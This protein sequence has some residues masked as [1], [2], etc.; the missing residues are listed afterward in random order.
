MANAASGSVVSKDRPAA[1]RAFFPLLEAL[2]ADAQFGG[3]GFNGLAALEQ[4]L[5]GGAFEV[6]VVSF[7]FARC[8][9]FSVHGVVSFSSHNHPSLVRQFE[10]RPLDDD[11]D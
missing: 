7:V 10:A 5:H 1:W 6:F 11:Y 9:V 4:H 3:N 2:A 8:V